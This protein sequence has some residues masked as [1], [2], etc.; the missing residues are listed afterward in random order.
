MYSSTTHSI[1]NEDVEKSRD[2]ERERLIDAG[3]DEEEEDFF[4][5]GPSAKKSVRFATDKMKNVQAQIS[6]VT[7]AMRDNVGRLLERGDQ[8]DNLNTRS[9]HLANTS[10]SFRNSS[11][12]LRRGLWWQN[13]RSKII[14]AAVALLLL[15][16]IFVPIII[17]YNT[18]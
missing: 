17:K 18:A 1:D 8:L 9:Q 11:V 6:D 4:L 14:L 7:E 15:I 3:D 12:R 2:D 16:V 13:T 10:D 5:K